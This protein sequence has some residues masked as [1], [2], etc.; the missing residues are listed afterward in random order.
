MRDPFCSNEVLEPDIERMVRCIR[1]GNEP[2]FPIHVE[3]DK[4]ECRVWRNF[5][6]SIVILPPVPM[7]VRYLPKDTLV[8][9]KK[10]YRG[11]YVSEGILIV[12]MEYV[13]SMFNDNPFIREWRTVHSHRVVI[14][15]EWEVVRI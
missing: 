8:E 6:G 5:D 13:R 1:R 7:S 2:D 9:V 3:P 12:D 15:S 11:K 10:R 14:K 4:P